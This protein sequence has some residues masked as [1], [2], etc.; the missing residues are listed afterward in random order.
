[1]PR[2][3]FRRLPDGHIDIKQN[4]S[5]LQAAAPVEFAPREAGFLA[6]DGRNASGGG[7]RFEGIILWACV[8]VL[9]TVSAY[10]A[11]RCLQF[12]QG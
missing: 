6:I 10:F 8:V 5:S 4:K 12:T 3:L 11:F 7:D 1:M 9:L 2:L